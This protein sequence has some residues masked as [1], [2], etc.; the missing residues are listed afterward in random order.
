MAVPS[1]AK[2]KDP[3]CL[4]LVEPDQHAIEY[5]GMHFA[6]C[7]PQ[8]QERFLANPHAYIGAPDAKAPKQEGREIIK[9]RRLRLAEPLSEAAAHQVTEQLL[10]MMG[11]YAVET[12]GQELRIT[13]DLLQATAEQVEATLLQAG[14]TLGGG[15]GEKLR[16]AF[17]HYIEET[18]VQNLE[19][20]PGRGGHGR[21]GGTHHHG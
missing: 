6:F 13:Y 18:E 5:L 17:V 21:G 14:T 2:V 19:V 9:R 1:R 16:R 15:W 8:C 11:V 12:H 7:S 4:M 3:V 20:R 10:A